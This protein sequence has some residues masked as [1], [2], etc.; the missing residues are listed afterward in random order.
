MPTFR[1]KRSDVKPGEVLCNY[2]SALC[3]RYFTLPI[4]TPESW[5]DYD[6]LRWYLIAPE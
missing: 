6:N 2:C 4:T 1:V 5:D 3:C